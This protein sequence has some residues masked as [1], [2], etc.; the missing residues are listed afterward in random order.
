MRINGLATP[1]VR[2][3]HTHASLHMSCCKAIP[4]K[5]GSITPGICRG[6]IQLDKSSAAIHLQLYSLPF[7][8]H[9][10]S[11]SLPATLKST[12]SKAHMHSI[13]ASGLKLARQRLERC[14]WFR[15]PLNEQL[16]IYDTVAG[17]TSEPSSYS[18][19]EHFFAQVVFYLIL[20]HKLD[21]LIE[22][23]IDASS[24][25]TL[26]FTAVFSV[27]VLVDFRPDMKIMCIW[28]DCYTSLH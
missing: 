22:A 4:R 25:K 3:P 24:P 15:L 11:H 19:G 23:Y 9:L 16:P 12:R 21:A 20:K 5:P 2:D 18:P 13:R 6:A 7:H 10:T 1:K 26:H 14:E 8:H 17:Q 28:C 27:V